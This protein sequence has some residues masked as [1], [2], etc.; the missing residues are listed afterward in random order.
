[1]TDLSG[2]EAAALACIDEAAIGRLLLEL[3]AIPSITGSGAESDLQHL[4]AARLQ[5]LGL[6][7]DLWSM[8][9]DKLALDP[10]FPGTE[11][12]RDEAWGLVADLPGAA[13]GPSLILQGHVDVVPPGD[14]SQWVTGPFEPRVDAAA[15]VYGR[16]TCDMKAGLV[17]N[18]AAMSAI[19]A[20]GI[21]LGGR[22]S[23]HCVVSEE[24]GGLGA[25]GTMRRGHLADACIITEPTSGTLTTANA[26]AL[27]FSI[28]VPGSAT[29][30][31]TRYAGTSAVDA[32]LPIHRAL[33]DL[34]RRRNAQVDPL[35]AEYPTAYCLSVGMIRAGDWASSVPDLLVAEGRLGVALDEDLATA[36][37]QFE[38]CVAEACQQDPW[39]RDHPATVSWS[40]GQ[41]AS[42][43]L[44][45]DHPLRDL[46]RG[47]HHELVGRS[48]MRERGAPYGSDLRIYAAAGVPTLHYG[49]GD[50]RTAHSP[51]EQVALKDVVEVARTLTL[52]VLRALG[53]R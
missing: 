26:G 35:M 43:R 28:R 9:L 6:D 15:I 21:R 30:G 44:Q 13:D 5:R 11:A 41:F 47:C 36:R 50:V 19:R 1:M 23:M 7:V 24:D 34:E 42:G 49:P 14:L 40:G 12:A 18:L 48:P 8:D 39:L 38:R 45:A 2:A 25:F 51:R 32:Y 22:L 29:H 31:S 10:D 20:S 4:L 33:T 53:T 52:T 17:A 27:T 46:V 16:G 3:L 37:D